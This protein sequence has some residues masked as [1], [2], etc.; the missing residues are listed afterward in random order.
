M[1]EQTP[2]Q[3][4]RELTTDVLFDVLHAGMA[5]GRPTPIDG[6]YINE[7]AD[8]FIAEVNRRL[9]K[10]ALTKEQLDNLPLNLVSEY[11]EPEDSDEEQI[12]EYQIVASAQLTASLEV[13]NGK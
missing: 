3:S 6:E 13:V 9:K 1:T 5:S 11:D 7:K 8:V 2:E 12:R 4:L 10:S